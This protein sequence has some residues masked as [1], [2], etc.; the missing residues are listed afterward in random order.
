MYIIVSLTTV[1]TN[2]TNHR[3][4]LILYAHTHYTHLGSIYEIES[5]FQNGYDN[6]IGNAIL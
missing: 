5:H 6:S 4:S 1:Y 3:E 2:I